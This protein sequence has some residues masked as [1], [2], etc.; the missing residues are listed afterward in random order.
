MKYA[1]CMFDFIIS[2][3]SYADVKDIKVYLR[4]VEYHPNKIKASPLE[5]L[6]IVPI[7]MEK[8]ENP[9]IEITTTQDEIYKKEIRLIGAKNQDSTIENYT[10]NTCYHFTLHNQELPLSPITV[11]DWT[12]GQVVPGYF[13]ANNIS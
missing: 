8:G 6:L 12:T 5:Y 2:D 3:I 13:I 11:S 4:D 10:E 1:Y 9:I 7:R